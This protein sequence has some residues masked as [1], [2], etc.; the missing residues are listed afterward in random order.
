[1]ASQRGKDFVLIFFFFSC[2]LVVS[3]YNLGV[4]FLKVKDVL[5]SMLAISS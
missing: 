1:M 2:K 5:L 4:T 3:D